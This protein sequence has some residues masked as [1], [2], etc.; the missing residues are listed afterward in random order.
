[1]PRLINKP[2]AYCLHKPSG[3]AKVKYRGK[4]T[5]L[6]KYGSS[7][8]KEAY[9]RF[10]ANLPKPDEQ[11]ALAAPSPGTPL[12][13]T[14]IILRYFRHTKVYY[15]KDGKPTGEHVTVRSS[16]RPVDEA[17]GSLP[18]RDFGPKCLKQVQQRMIALGWSRRYINKATSIVKRCFVW[19]ASEELIDA[20]TAMA[21]RT[22]PGLLKGRTDARE[23]APVG[24]VSEAHIVAIFPHVSSLVVAVARDATNRRPAL[25]GD[26]HDCRRSRSD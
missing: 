17:F 23:K 2:P 21:L 11:T 10:V 26:Q 24:P 16:L 18:A 14:E 15:A 8:S 3:L 5:Y 25:R 9:A 1:M 22:V 4:I 7:E 20:S 13:V 6:G 19:C 12:L